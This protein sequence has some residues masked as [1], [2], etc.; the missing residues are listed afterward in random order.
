M[1]KHTINLLERD[2]SDMNLQCDCKRKCN[3]DGRDCYIKFAIKALEK[4]DKYRWHDLRKNP[5]D[6]P[7]NLDKSVMYTCV[8]ENH[9][10]DPEY[11]AY[12]FNIEREEFG[13]WRNVFDDATL[14]FCV[15]DTLSD[16]GYERV[17]A[18]REI[19]PFKAG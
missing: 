16:L 7:R 19:E 11:P 5:K 13:F 9:L 14:G 10:Y 3:T 1:I 12:Y 8:H 2:C 18:W 15:F 6:L 17:I 4:A